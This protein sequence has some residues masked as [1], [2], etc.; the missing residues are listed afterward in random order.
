MANA[1]LVAEN[2]SESI[3]FGVKSLR[4]FIDFECYEFAARKRDEFN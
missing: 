3:L 1:S 2:F 4:T